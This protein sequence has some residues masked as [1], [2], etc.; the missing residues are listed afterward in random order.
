MSLDIEISPRA[1]VDMLSF[2]SP[3]I[4]YYNILRQRINPE[5]SRTLAKHKKL[6][7]GEQCKLKNEEWI[8][9]SVMQ[10]NGPAQINPFC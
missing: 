10:R 8:D 6:S 2:P 7:L 3:F 5:M 1:C 9:V 4:N